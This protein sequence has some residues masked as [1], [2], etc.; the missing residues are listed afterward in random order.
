MSI[1][2]LHKEPSIRST[3]KSSKPFPSTCIRSLHSK[4]PPTTCYSQTNP[5]FQSLFSTTTV[6]LSPHLSLSF[7]SGFRSKKHPVVRCSISKLANMFGDFVVSL[8]PQPSKEEVIE[9]LKKYGNY[10]RALQVLASN[11]SGFSVFFMNR[12][13]RPEFFRGGARRI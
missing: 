6:F 7:P 1:K 2:C 5:P 11:F 8:L 4:I 3:E 10:K 13:G 9:G 12:K